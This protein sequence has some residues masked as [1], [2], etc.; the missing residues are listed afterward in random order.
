MSPDDRWIVVAGPTAAGKTEVALRLSE[1]FGGEIVNADSRQVYRHM[2]VGTAKPTL[3][4]RSIVPH[5]LFD[6]VDPDEH[7]DAAC[8][9]DHGRTALRGIW[10]RGRLPI[11]VGGTGLYLRA[12]SR[13]LFRG[14]GAVAA[15]RRVLEQL[16][17]DHPGMLARWCRRVDPP[18]AARLHPHDRVRLIRALEVAI[19]TG[20]PL[21]RHQSRHSFGERL[22]TVLEIVLH[23]GDEVL[24]RK[25]D[26][27]SR[28]MLEGGLLD[29]VRSLR[30]RGYGPELRVLR[31][32]GYREA[33]RV[34]DGEWD[35]DQAITE[36]TRSTWRFARRQ[37]AWFRGEREAIWIDPVDSDRVAREVEAFLARG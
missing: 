19:T 10:S 1:R 13:G 28:G 26:A 29:E 18:I 11:V 20:E 14:P 31:S 21:S 25:I 8:Y 35:R 36:L 34:L 37:L 15:L 30:A 33:G 12:L 7:F 32:I 9:R 6:V 24:A 22:G 3:A 2:D 23:P 16:E 5:H 4:E 17:E 27:R